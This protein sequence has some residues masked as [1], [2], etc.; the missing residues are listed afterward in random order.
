[1]T[2]H[3][4]LSASSS[5]RWL[6]CAGSVAM[7]KDIPDQSSA[8]AEEGTVAHEVASR[9][10]STLANPP[11]YLGY[12]FTLR[13]GKILEAQKDIFEAKTDKKYVVNQDM[14]EHVASYIQVVHDFTPPGAQRFI[15]ER[16]DFS[17]AIGVPNSF[18][19][20]DVIIIHKD[21]ITI[22]DLKFGQGVLVEAERNPQLMLYALGALAKYSLIYDF[23]RVRMVIHQ[24][25]LNSL[26]EWDCSVTDLEAFAE[27]A[28]KAARW[29]KLLLNKVDGVTNADLNPGEKQCRFCKARGICPALASQ[30]MNLIADDFVDLTKEDET[31][32]QLQNAVEVIP[33]ADEG[34]LANMLKGASLVETWIKGVREAAFAKLASGGA[35][36]GFKL[37]RGRQGPRRWR[38]E[39][40]AVGV[41]EVY[42]AKLEEIFKKTL[43]SP[44]EAEKKF[45]T[46]KE[47]LNKLESVTTRS[48]GSLS[49]APESDKRPPV[50]ADDISGDFENLTEG[51]E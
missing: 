51:E 8:F 49:V 11:H 32:R 36:K 19:T 15:E 2:A 46:N 6:A 21:E 14:V 17:K 3:A 10:L 7:E 48:E 47:L 50:L 29:A 44:T 39:G 23:K 41:F 42:Q 37:V 35:I 20:S 5:H 43:I 34:R 12:E 30:A 18:G 31:I 4:L 9:C 45:K 26:S 22:I 28:K 24:P 33:N 16:V 13:D 1:M 27:E 40:S 25:R 38:D